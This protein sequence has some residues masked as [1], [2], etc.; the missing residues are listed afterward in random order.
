MHV[1]VLCTWTCQIE[2]QIECRI[3]S[4]IECKTKS[5]SKCQKECQMQCPNR[6]VSDT[7]MPNKM[8]QFMSN[9]MSKMHD[10]MRMP[11][12]CQL[13]EVT[14]K[15]LFISFRSIRHVSYFSRNAAS[16]EQAS[17]D[18]WENLFW[19]P[20]WNMGVFK[21]G[22]IQNPKMVVL[23]NGKSCSNR[24]FRGTMISGNFHICW[25]FIWHIFWHSICHI[26]WHV[27]WHCNLA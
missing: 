19:H 7:R 4:Q 16:S 1:H 9:R 15:N 22:G 5:Q 17:A 14:W 12:E 8:L 11:L 3:E 18:R 26:F 21:T 24:W 20:V 2:H 10:R 13:V 27:I 25:D 6:I 23:Y